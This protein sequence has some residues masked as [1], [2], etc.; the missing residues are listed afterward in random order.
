MAHGSAENLHRDNARDE[1]RRRVSGDGEKGAWCLML[2]EVVPC[3]GADR[4]L[5]IVNAI[6]NGFQMLLITLLAHRVKKNGN[7]H[8]PPLPRRSQKHGP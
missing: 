1:G 2:P 6:F 7:G 4:S 8:A 5:D 3:V